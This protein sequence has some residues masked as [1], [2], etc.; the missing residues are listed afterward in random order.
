MSLRDERNWP[1]TFD[2]H[3]SNEGGS[4]MQKLELQIILELSF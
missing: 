2:P 3:R 1:L 4:K